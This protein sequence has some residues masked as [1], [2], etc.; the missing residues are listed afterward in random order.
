MTKKLWIGIAIFL[1]AVVILLLAVQLWP[2]PEKA[3]IVGICYREGGSKE[4]AGYREK[5][6]KAL[7]GKGYQLIVK[8][9]DRDQSKQ[10]T[11]IQELAQQECDVLLIEPVMTDS[12]PE[13]LE[14]VEQ[15]GIP[16]VLFNK[17]MD[18]TL[19]QPY[20]DVYY[21]GYPYSNTVL[22]HM[23]MMTALSD[24][25]D[26]NGDGTVACLLLAD[27]QEHRD[28]VQYKDSLLACMPD[29][30]QILSEVYTE[31]T[32]ESG[33][34]MCKQE[35]A[36]YG[37]DIEVILCGSDQIALGADQAITDGGRTVG[38]DVYLF[39]IGGDSEGMA[40]ISLGKMTGTV[41]ADPT[42]QIETICKTVEQLFQGS[43]V[44]KIQ[45]LPFVSVTKEN[46]T[47]YW[48]AE[49]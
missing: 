4:N 8:D 29:N 39:G 26:W 16:A 24:G 35:L 38:K 11:Q 19:F 18:A 25:G 46:V 40:L 45:V 3:D 30:L 20:A 27:P 41:Y 33:R 17:P 21:I 36:T 1:A 13:M 2:K 34:K 28:S 42:L 49:A 48:N 32:L 22:N 31:G 14:K 5:L 15:L 9:A 47:D 43:A 23:E 10:L 6:E 12:A 44:D 37:K 7:S